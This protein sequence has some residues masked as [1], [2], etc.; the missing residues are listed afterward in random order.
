[1]ISYGF[2]RYWPDLGKPLSS[3]FRFWASYKVWRI[4]KDQLLALYILNIM[5]PPLHTD[6]WCLELW[7]PPWHSAVSGLAPLCRSALWTGTVVSGEFLGA[8]SRPGQLVIMWRYYCGRYNVEE[9]EPPSNPTKPKWTASLIQLLISQILKRPTVSSGPPNL[10]EA[11]VWRQ[12]SMSRH[13]S[14]TTAIK[15]SFTR[16]SED[17][18]QAL[19]PLAVPW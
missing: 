12:K 16:S 9:T 14:E 4:L 15:P 2:L 7:S 3:D 17:V 13:W 18:N 6:S 1:M 10:R 5:S 19:E 11:S 8:L